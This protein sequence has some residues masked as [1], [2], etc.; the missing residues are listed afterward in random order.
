MTFPNFASTENTMNETS[1]ESYVEK[2]KQLLEAEFLFS[3]S[4]HSLRE[5]ALA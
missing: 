3:Y 4:Y 2:E 1:R 5:I